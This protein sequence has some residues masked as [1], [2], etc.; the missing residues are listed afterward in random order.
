M[1]KGL[2]NKHIAI[3]KPFRKLQKLIPTNCSC[4]KNNA[5]KIFCFAL[6]QMLTV[7]AICRVKVLKDAHI[8]RGHSITT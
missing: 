8:D 5:F 4:T 1:T 3:R 2:Y 7:D 6:K